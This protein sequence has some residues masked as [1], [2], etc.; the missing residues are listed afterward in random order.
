[1]AYNQDAPSGLMT[2]RGLNNQDSMPGI[3][4]RISPVCAWE[5]TLGS[6]KEACITPVTLTP[7]FR[8]EPA[9]S[10]LSRKH[11][12][13]SPFELEDEMSVSTRRSIKNPHQRLH[14]S[15]TRNVSS[16]NVASGLV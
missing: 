15:T 11:M 6:E 3:N 16:R 12:T 8:P 9:A 13:H 14:T 7:T 5:T 1:M 4:L 2:L 10:P